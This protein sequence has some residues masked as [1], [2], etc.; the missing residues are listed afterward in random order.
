MLN[1]SSDAVAVEWAQSFERFKNHERES[2]LPNIFLIA[3][4]VKSP[5]PLWIQQHR[6]I[7][8]YGNAIGDFQRRSRA[9]NVNAV[10]TSRT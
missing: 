10:R 9:Q 6:A 5:L 1:A 2:A 8:F 4:D 3:H 7:A